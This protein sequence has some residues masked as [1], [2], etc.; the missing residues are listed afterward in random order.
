MV[1]VYARAMEDDV[2]LKPQGPNCDETHDELTV[3]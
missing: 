1:L 2:A 3:D